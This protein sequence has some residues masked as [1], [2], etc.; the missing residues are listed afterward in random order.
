VFVKQ[1]GIQFVCAICE[2]RDVESM[3]LLTLRNIFF[4]KDGTN[5]F[6]FNDPLQIKILHLRKKN[7]VSW[8]L[9]ASSKYEISSKEHL[10][11]L[12]HQGSLYTDAGTPPADYWDGDYEQTVDIDLAADANITPIG[13]SGDTFTGTYDGSNFSISNWSFS[14]T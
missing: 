2:M 4:A 1:R 6:D 3:L 10:L 5:G 13:V 9:N 8:V 11:Q 7:M 14:E 12:M